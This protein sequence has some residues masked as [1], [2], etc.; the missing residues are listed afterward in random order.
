M[1]GGI[2]MPSLPTMQK[3]SSSA[4]ALTE[5]TLG[6]AVHN[7]IQPYY[8]C[9]EPGQRVLSERSI[10]LKKMPVDVTS[11][12]VE[13]WFVEGCGVRP[14][15]VYKDSAAKN[16]DGDG[17]IVA[18]VAEFRSEGDCHEQEAVVEKAFSLNNSSE[19]L[20]RG[21]RLV[22]QRI[23][24]AARGEV[25]DLPQTFLIAIRTCLEKAQVW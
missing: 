17:Q 16:R 6:H 4:K 19:H 1:T 12:E 10:R 21:A 2:S 23:R 14:T 7:L 9:A 11:R 20:F 18:M 8:A 13:D 25:Q 3:A 5:H 24:K 22:L 15:A